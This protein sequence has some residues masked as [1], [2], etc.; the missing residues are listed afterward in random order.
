[1]ESG[2]FQSDLAQTMLN[3]GQH[4]ECSILVS[5]EEVRSEGDDFWNDA[6]VLRAIPLH[7][8]VVRLV[9]NESLEQFSQFK[10]MFGITGVPCLAYFGPNV[11]TIIKQWEPFPS[12]DEFCEYFATKPKPKPKPQDL[13]RRPQRDTTRISVQGKSGSIVREF[14]KDDTLAALKEWIHSE[15]DGAFTVIVSHTH[16]P[17]PSNDSLTLEQMDMCPNCV[18]RLVDGDV[19]DTTIVI[20]GAADQQRNEPRE[21]WHCPS[22]SCS[23][24]K[25]AKLGYSLLNPWSEDPQTDDEWRESGW[26]F[27]P[28]PEKATQIREAARMHG[29]AM[30]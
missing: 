11:A 24:W 14:S 21:P 3:K 16:Q 23:C 8:S 18:L 4:P 12:V 26:Q 1:M 15:I 30:Q 10:D 7:A 27:R 2:I 9:Q 25:Y 5:W 28:D 22:P 17:L 20:D 19:P 29:G 13:P 6:Q